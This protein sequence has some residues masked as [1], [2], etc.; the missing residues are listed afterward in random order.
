MWIDL[1]TTFAKNI[2]GDGKTLVQTLS[3]I[4]LKIKKTA[5]TKDLMCY[6][7]ILSDASMEICGGKFSKIEY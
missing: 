3:G 1:H 6:I 5:T 4:L 2:N 7:F